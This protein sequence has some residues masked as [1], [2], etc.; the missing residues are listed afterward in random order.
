MS[1]GTP[2]GMYEIQFR[3]TGKRRSEGWKSTGYSSSSKAE[4]TMRMNQMDAGNVEHRL[5]FTPDEGR[6]LGTA[7]NTRE[8]R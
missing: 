5:F 2:E 8:A 6:G 1:Y 3:W 4:S 7:R